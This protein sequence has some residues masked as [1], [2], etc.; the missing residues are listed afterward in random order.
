MN[1][2]SSN[3]FQN[4]PSLKNNYPK[5]RLRRTAYIKA[6]L[7]NPKL[8]S[9]QKLTEKLAKKALLSPKNQKEFRK[10]TLIK[11]RK[12]NSHEVMKNP[13][14]KENIIRSIKATKG[15]YKPVFKGSKRK[16]RKK[17]KCGFGL[18]WCSDSDFSKRDS[19]KVD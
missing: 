16:K 17:H 13:K 7:S 2:E 4:S 15:Y 1:F 18:G 19:F 6:I 9:T 3:A 12:R 11:T 8:S 14:R 5:S 10:L